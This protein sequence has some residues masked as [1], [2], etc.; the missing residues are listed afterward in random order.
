MHTIG[1]SWVSGHEPYAENGKYTVCAYCHGS[2][3]RGSFLSATRT[4]RTF[5]TES[6]QKTFT[7]G[8]QFS[9]FDCHNGPGVWIPPTP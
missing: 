9:C 8:H 3:Y 2:D 7:A 5:N 1:Q 4:N 6:G